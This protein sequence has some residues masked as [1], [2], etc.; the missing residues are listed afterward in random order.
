MNKR[1][2]EQWIRSE[3]EWYT[4]L[5]KKKCVCSTKELAKVCSIQNLR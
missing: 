5:C 2:Q 3:C 1:Q 4:Q